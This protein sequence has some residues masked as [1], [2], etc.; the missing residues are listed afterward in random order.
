MMM[1]RRRRKKRRRERR[2]KCLRKKERRVVARKEKKKRKR[3][4]RQRMREERR[5]NFVSSRNVA[6]GS[7]ITNR[8]AKRWHR[9]SHT[10]RA[11]NTKGTDQKQEE[12]TKTEQGEEENTDRAFGPSCP[13]AL[14][15]LVPI[16]IQLEE[17]RPGRTHPKQ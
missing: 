11:N 1:M 3:R 5:S 10:L 6:I 15:S 4:K 16:L 13:F 2:K 14:Q 17:Q 8:I 7:P 12:G 9:T